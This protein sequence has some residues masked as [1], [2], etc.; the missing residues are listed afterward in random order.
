MKGSA[1]RAG[2]H[3][4]EDALRPRAAG[5]FMTNSFPAK[6]SKSSTVNDSRNELV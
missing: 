5:L 3:G 1:K 2:K 6:N 4:V